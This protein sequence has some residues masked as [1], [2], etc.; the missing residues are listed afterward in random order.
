MTLEDIYTKK[1]KRASGLDELKEMYDDMYWIEREVKKRGFFF[2]RHYNNTGQKLLE[3]E[4]DPYKHLIVEHLYEVTNCAFEQTLAWQ[5]DKKW[6][7]W[8]K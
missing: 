6:W 2:K 3:A 8:Y 7:E 4:E 5:K 1:L